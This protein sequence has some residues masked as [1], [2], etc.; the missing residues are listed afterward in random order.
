M[1]ESKSEKFKW[2]R[3]PDLYKDSEIVV[4]NK[5]DKSNIVVSSEQ[6][7]SLFLR[8]AFNCIKNCKSILLKMF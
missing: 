7:S 3:I 2:I 8:D 4:T 5:E 6:S 1:Q